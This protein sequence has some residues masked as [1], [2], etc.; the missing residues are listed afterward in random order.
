MTSLTFIILMSYLLDLI[1]RKDFETSRINVYV[2]KYNLA[3]SSKD[4][5]IDMNIYFFSHHS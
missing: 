2:T 1:S 5:I 3:I 4:F